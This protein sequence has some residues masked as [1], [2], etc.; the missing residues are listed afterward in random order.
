MQQN[1]SKQRSPKRRQQTVESCIQIQKEKI[2]SRKVLFHSIN[3]YLNQ[4]TL[5]LCGAVKESGDPLQFQSSF[6]TDLRYYAIFQTTLTFVTVYQAE[7]S[8]Q[9]MIRSLVS[10]DGDATNQVCQACLEKPQF[11]LQITS[12]HHWLIHQLMRQ[13]R[14]QAERWTNGFS[15]LISSLLTGASVLLNLSQF[16]EMHPTFWLLPLAMSWLLQQGIKR[17]LR[18]RMPSLH[19]WLLRQLLLGWFSRGQRLRNMALGLLEWFGI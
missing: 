15:W 9:V 14:F 1:L 18:W 19:R 2:T 3:F 7:E 17:L 11:A 5:S 4:E 6:L 10:L 16:Q 13:L 12:I 8:E